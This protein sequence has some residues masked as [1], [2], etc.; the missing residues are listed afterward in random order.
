MQTFSIPQSFRLSSSLPCHLCL[1]ASSFS[2]FLLHRSVGE[3]IEHPTFLA[4]TRPL[5]D[6]YSTYSSPSSCNDKRNSGYIDVVVVLNAVG[7]LYW[8]KLLM[9]LFLCIIIDSMV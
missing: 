3:A 6:L 2:I 7:L 9:L 4:L 5:C 8:S 1:S